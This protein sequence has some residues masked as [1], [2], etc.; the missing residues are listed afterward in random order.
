MKRILTIDGGGMRGY[1]PA[2]V[3]IELERIAG[4]PY[5]E[6]FDMIAGTSIGGILAALLAVGTPAGEAIK[7]FTEDGPKI[8]KKSCWRAWGLFCPRYPAQPLES[9]LE[10]RF[11]GKSISDCK[12]KLLVAS[13]DLASQNPFFFENF[14][15]LC[16]NYPLW[17]VG[18]GTSAAQTYFPAFPLDHR[19]LWDGGNVANN[20]SVCAMADAVNLWGGHELPKQVL[21][22][23]C[24]S[25]KATLD[26]RTLVNA[27]FIRNGLAT[28][29]MLFEAGP[30][31]A[32]YQMTAV[33]GKN[34]YRIQPAIGDLPLDDASPDG[35]AKLEMAAKKNIPAAL[36]TIQNFLSGKEQ[37]RSSKWRRA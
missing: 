33:L 26:A 34:Y 7:F 25:Q 27:G 14:S 21:S 30:E 3:L 32:D 28:V 37:L 4:K 22:L 31:D 2:S 5:C 11:N 23:G 29:Q 16:P 17:Q 20:P 36:E 35:L 9:A 10:A 18:R 1:L 19:I 6:M 8:F 24:G 12:T 13:L 15:G